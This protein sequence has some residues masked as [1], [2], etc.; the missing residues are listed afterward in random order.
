MSDLA[1]HT[2]S[3]HKHYSSFHAVMGIK[4]RLC[5]NTATSCTQSTASTCAFPAARFTDLWVKTAREKPPPSACS[6]GS[7]V[8]RQ[9]TYR[10]LAS[11]RYTERLVGKGGGIGGF[12]ELKTNLQVNEKLEFGS[13]V[14]VQ[15]L[16]CLPRT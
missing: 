9:A 7:H 8:Q 1:I 12:R 16:E 3:L 13:A 6:P 2:Q 10:S 15:H 14:S 11:I 4:Y 5:T